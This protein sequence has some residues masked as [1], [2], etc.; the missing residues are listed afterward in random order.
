MPTV[1]EFPAA[2][3]ATVLRSRLWLGSFSHRFASMPSA[4][5]PPW[6]NGSENSNFTGPKQSVAPGCLL[7]QQP[8][9]RAKALRLTPMSM[10]PKDW[11]NP[12]THCRP[13]TSDD[14]PFISR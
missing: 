2:A 3:R 8:L 12:H 14:K 1:P 9:T 7:T 11:D 5:Q 4:A 13:V 6:A 10:T